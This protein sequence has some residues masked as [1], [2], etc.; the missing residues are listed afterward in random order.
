MKQKDFWLK[1]IKGM[2]LI[3]TMINIPLYIYYAAFCDKSQFSILTNNVKR[4]PSYFLKVIVTCGLPIH[5]SNSNLMDYLVKEENSGG[6]FLL[7]V[8]S[9]I[10]MI[11]I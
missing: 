3:W 11:D 6:I 5:K 8:E 9:E 10:R 4:T 1:F 2:L 7:T